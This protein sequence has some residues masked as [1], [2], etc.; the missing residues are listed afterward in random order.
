MKT[1]DRQRKITLIALSLALVVAVYLNW[2]YSR[3]GTD[4][5]TLSE[6]LNGET[7]QTNTQSLVMNEEGDMLA[8]ANE[9][10]TENYGDA[11]LVATTSKSSDKYFEETRLARQK[12]RD[13]ALSVLQDTLKSS[14]LSDAEKTQ[15]TEKLSQTIQNITTETDI[16]N[17]VKA[18]GFADCVAFIDDGSISIAVKP[19]SGD[20]TKQNTAQIRDI[21]LSKTDISSQNIVIIEVK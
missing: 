14:K 10:E 5:S 18:K 8:V 19:S 6:G 17:L 3:T 11:Q 16:E 1:L 12:S 7:V 4:I 2:Q 21:V 13:E 15:A 9:S 20:L